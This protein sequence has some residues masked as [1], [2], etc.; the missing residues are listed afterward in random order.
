ML[1]S[2]PVGLGLSVSLRTH[3]IDSFIA[4]EHRYAQ[5]ATSQALPVW[6]SLAKELQDRYRRIHDNLHGAKAMLKK[7][8]QKKFPM[9]NRS[10]PI[11]RT[12]HD[13]YQP[14]KDRWPPSMTSVWPVIHPALSG[15]AKNSVAA[16]MSWGVPIRFNGLAFAAF[17]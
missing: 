5:Q 12:K 7:K 3:S 4:M 14:A 11:S 13:N 9:T 8:K 1:L 6:P 2:S 10:P 16:A 17:S 15:S